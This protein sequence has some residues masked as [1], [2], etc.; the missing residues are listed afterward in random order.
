M[1]VEVATHA[2]GSYVFDLQRRYWFAV[3]YLTGLVTAL[4]VGA[5]HNVLARRQFCSS[6]G[7]HLKVK[8]C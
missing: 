5:L 6:Q 8:S 2:H 3:R 4:A 7:R 1:A